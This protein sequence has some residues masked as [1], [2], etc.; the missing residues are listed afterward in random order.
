MIRPGEPIIVLVGMQRKTTFWRQIWSGAHAAC[1]APL[2]VSESC[3]SNCGHVWHLGRWG[4]HHTCCRHTRKIVYGSIG[5]ILM[6]NVEKKSAQDEPQKC[7]SPCLPQPMVPDHRPQTWDSWWYQFPVRY[8][9]Y[10]VAEA[11]Q[12]RRNSKFDE[13]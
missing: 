2:C 13:I 3:P 11:S 6:I 7:P 9:L 8:T 10:R 5:A 1:V 4:R 12:R